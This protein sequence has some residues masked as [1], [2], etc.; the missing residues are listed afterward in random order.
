MKEKYLQQIQKGIRC[1]NSY[2]SSKDTLSKLEKSSTLINTQ[3]SALLFIEK[4]SYSFWRLYFYIQ[5][6]TKINWAIFEEK[7]LGN[8]LKICC[9]T[10]VT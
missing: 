8:Q 5:D 9:F 2:W 10:K 7:A 3:L 1:T 4:T 6:F